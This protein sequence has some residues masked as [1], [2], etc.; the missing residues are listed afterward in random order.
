MCVCGVHAEVEDIV[1][2]VTTHYSYLFFAINISMFS[3]SGDYESAFDTLK[4]AITL[5][6][7]SVTANSESSL[8]GANPVIHLC[9]FMYPVLWHIDAHSVLARLPSEH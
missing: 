9:C 5:I 8:V 4:M 7:Q 1:S 6:K 3:F 2:I